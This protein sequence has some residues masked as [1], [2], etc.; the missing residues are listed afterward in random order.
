MAQTAAKVEI[1]DKVEAEPKPVEVDPKQVV[2]N[3]AGQC[4]RTVL[5]RMPEGMV[6]DDLRSP[7][8]WKKVQ[9]NRQ[10][11][12]VKLDRLFVLA[13]DESWHCEAIVS[14]ATGTEAHL[15]ITKTGSFRTQSE[16]LYTDGVYAVF[17]S[18][19]GGYGIR[20]VSDGIEMGAVSWTTEGQAIQGIRDLYPKQV[21]GTVIGG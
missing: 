10:S 8:I 1:E 15:C 6:Q 17:W 9:G 19:A 11:V 14:Y 4:W 3:N 7:K 20:R 18:G 12:L 16:Q 13:H 2:V 5:V 21:G